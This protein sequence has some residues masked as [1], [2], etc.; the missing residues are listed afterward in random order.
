MSKS[1]KHE[2]TRGY[3]DTI[4]SQRRERQAARELKAV[5]L[6]DVEEAIFSLPLAQDFS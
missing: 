3:L 2:R 4:A 5:V 1:V 6:N